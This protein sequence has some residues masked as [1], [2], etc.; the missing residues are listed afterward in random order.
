MLRAGGQIHVPSARLGE[1]TGGQ[2][3]RFADGADILLAG[4]GGQGG[5]LVGVIIKHL[6]ADAAGQ[7]RAV[8]AVVVAAQGLLVLLHALLQVQHGAD[9]GGV[10]GVAQGVMGRAAGLDAEDLHRGLQGLL[11]GGAVG[12]GVEDHLSVVPPIHP[13]IGQLVQLQVLSQDGDVVKA[14]GQ[15][16]HVLAAPGAELL[17]G[18]GEGDALGLQPGFLDARQLADPAVQA[19]V[20]LGP[21]QDLELIQD[22][23]LLADPDGTHLDDLA[24]DLDR[25]DLPG[26]GGTGPGLVPFH[27]QYNVIHC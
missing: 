3:S 8:E 16:D 18:L 24:P 15:E 13:F 4:H 2:H 17:D 6:P 25:Q 20:E 1:P 27:I 5:A 23:L 7:L 12:L 22:Q 10:V 14:P 9:Q 26:R 19:P 11:A 21:H